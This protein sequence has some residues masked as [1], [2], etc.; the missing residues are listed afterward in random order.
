MG[1]QP[2]YL[3]YIEDSARTIAGLDGKRMLEFGDQ[4]IAS[5]IF[6]KT[7]KK[8][9]E[10]RGVAHTSFDLNGK[11]GSIQVDLGEPFHNPEWL[12]AFDI[13]TNA[14]TS[15]HVEPFER[16]YVVFMN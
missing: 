14:G 11:R 16:Q 3:K 13:V 7:A 5:G 8:Y 1:L 9:F 4:I 15:E 10:R 12:D 2:P 6:P